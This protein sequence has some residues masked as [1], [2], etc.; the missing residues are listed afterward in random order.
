[1]QHFLL[2]Q[3][4][5][6]Y[7]KLLVHEADHGLRRTIAAML[8]AAER[9]LALSEAAARG[10]TRGLPAA[11]GETSPADRASM[12]NRFREELAASPQ[13][14]LLLHPGPGL[15]I[16]DLN[17]A[18]AEATLIDRYRVPG[19][20]L[21]DVFPDNPD[22]PLADGVNR[23]YHSLTTAIETGRTHHMAI[24]RYDVR[25]ADGRFVERHWQPENRPIF[26]FDGRLVALLHRAKDVTAEVLAADKS[27][28]D[29][30][31]ADPI[32]PVRS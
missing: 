27:P 7:R 8:A 20:R 23:L 6:R 9:E 13:P 25:D 31:Q 16:L 4:I 28:P 2:Q 19:E 3:N 1:M 24:Q 29:E 21:F 26:D 14:M 30:S 17:P 22:D 11:F 18:Y 10:A 15:H 12:R 32:P 5:V